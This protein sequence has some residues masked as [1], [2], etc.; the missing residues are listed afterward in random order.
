VRLRTWAEK[1]LPEPLYL[2]TEKHRTDSTPA[3]QTD[4]YPAPT[5]L[6]LQASAAEPLHTY[7]SHSG[8]GRG[9]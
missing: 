9:S 6:H 1:A 8:H 2:Q 4:F 3:H 7:P 5:P